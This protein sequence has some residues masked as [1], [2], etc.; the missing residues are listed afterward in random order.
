[1]KIKLIKF[2]GSLNVVS[3]EMVSSVV[4]RGTWMSQERERSG[5]Q[6]WL[7]A[8]IPALRHMWVKFP[9]G[10][11]LPS[12]PPGANQKPTFP[13]FQLHLE[14]GFPCKY[15]SRGDTVTYFTWFLLYN[16]FF[17]FNPDV[18]FPLREYRKVFNISKIFG[19]VGQS[20]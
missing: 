16:V 17:L 4:L 1:M 15:S 7:V 10:P 14:R 2:L 6:M 18:T 13:K 9:L 20:I 8:L 3:Y 12:P 19:I 11:C 5:P